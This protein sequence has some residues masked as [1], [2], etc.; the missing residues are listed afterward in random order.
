[1]TNSTSRLLSAMATVNFAKKSFAFVMPL[2]AT[3]V[4]YLNCFRKIVFVVFF[5]FYA[6]LWLDSI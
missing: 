2:W 3:G 5:N 4:F 1:M 6:Y